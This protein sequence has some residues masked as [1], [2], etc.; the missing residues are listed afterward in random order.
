[1]FETKLLAVNRYY[2]VIA[3]EGYWDVYMIDENGDSSDY[4]TYCHQ[5]DITYC[6]GN[7]EVYDDTVET[8]VYDPDATSL[9]NDC[10]YTEC[11]LED[12]DEDD[13]IC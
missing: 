7:W 8:W 5:E 2:E 3:G 13:T 11:D 6:A 10:T 4:L 1:M 12:Y 9:Y